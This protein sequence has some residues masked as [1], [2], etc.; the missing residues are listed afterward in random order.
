MSVRCDV[1]RFLLDSSV[2][3]HV[4]ISINYCQ[5]RMRRRRSVKLS[6]CAL[7]EV[8]VLHTSQTF[9]LYGKRPLRRSVKTNC[10]L[11]GTAKAFHIRYDH[12]A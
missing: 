11:C 9:T 12:K 10:P 3:I 1:I 4:Q 7:A 5:E 2:C 8:V 6:M